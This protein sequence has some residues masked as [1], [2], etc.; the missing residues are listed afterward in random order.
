MA[1]SWENR[2]KLL[3]LP[4]PFY[5]RRKLTSESRKGEPEIDILPDLLGDR[6]GTA[7]DVGANRGIYSYLLSRYFDRVLAFEPNP[8]LAEFGRRMLPENVEVIEAALGAHQFSGKLHIPGGRKGGEDHLT[9][10]LSSSMTAV[11]TIPV[12]VLTLDSLDIG[13]VGFIKI[14]VEGTEV[15]VIKGARNTI[16][17]DRPLLMAEILA[18]LYDDPVETVQQ[19]CTDHAYQARVVS[20]SGLVDAVDYL[21][22]GLSVLSRN[23]LFFPHE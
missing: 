7:I 4:G 13:R 19:I 17:R 3:F 22:S 21:Q 8:D 18:G 14:D 23:V 11:R 15:E 12:D 6:G 2:L 1:L 10:T 20:P 5:Y 9:A 16:A